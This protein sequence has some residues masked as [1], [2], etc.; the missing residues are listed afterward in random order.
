MEFCNGLLSQLIEC[1]ESTQNEV[2]RKMN[3][4]AVESLRTK[5]TA[6]EI[7]SK[8]FSRGQILRRGFEFVTHE[9]VL[10]RSAEKFGRRGIELIAREARPRGAHRYAHL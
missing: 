8:S 4:A 9:S 5:V 6:G 1:I 2:K 10:A 3:L 7:A